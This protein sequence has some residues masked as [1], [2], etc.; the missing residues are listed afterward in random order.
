ME[1]N[2][3]VSLMSSLLSS[4]KHI[5]SVKTERYILHNATQRPILDL[6]IME[7][8]NYSLISRHKRHFFPIYPAK[9]GSKNHLVWFTPPTGASQVWVVKN[10]PANAGEVGSIPGSGRSPGGGHGNPLQYSCL[11]NPMDRGVWWATDHGVAEGCRLKWL[12][13][14]V[15]SYRL[16]S[17]L[18]KGK[19][20]VGRRTFT[21]KVETRRSGGPAVTTKICCHE[22]WTSQLL[23]TPENPQCNVHNYPSFKVFEG[24]KVYICI[25]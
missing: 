11:E 22:L 17:R 12:S 9:W 23:T 5:M 8:G 7:T 16:H 13:S 3:A 2:I 21:R 4:H 18:S 6:F 10:P 1:G 14:H 25:F 19:S 20:W 15:H 24:V